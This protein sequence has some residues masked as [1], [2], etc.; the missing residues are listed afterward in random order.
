MEVM[1]DIETLSTRPNAI[2]LII[3]AIKFKRTEKYNE[4][5]DDKIL[6][7]LDTFYRRITIS[8]CTEVGLIQSKETVNWWESQKDEIKKEAFTD[9]NRVSLQEALKSFS[10][11]FKEGEKNSRTLIWGNGS[12]FDITILGEAYNRCNIEIP[13]K[14]WLVRDLRTL[15]DIGNIK[16]IDLPQY[17]LHHALYDCYRQ[18]I[19]LTRAIKNIYK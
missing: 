10:V 8:S 15:L 5:I 6:N 11:W 13:W 1:L 12:D 18:I 2:I 14:F 17:N 19:G 3:G 16:M 7:K 9:Q 4:N